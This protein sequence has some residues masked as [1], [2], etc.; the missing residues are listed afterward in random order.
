MTDILVKQFTYT[1][2]TSTGSDRIQ[3][4]YT[5]VYGDGILIREVSD[6]IVTIS[7][8]AAFAKK[9]QAI[10]KYGITAKDGTHYKLDTPVKDSPIEQVREQ[11]SKYNQDKA[12]KIAF[13]E[14]ESPDMSFAKNIAKNNAIKEFGKKQ[15]IQN[16]TVNGAV[17][18]EEKLYRSDRGHYIYLLLVEVDAIIPDKAV[19]EQNTEGNSAILGDA[20]KTL[21]TGTSEPNPDN[22]F[23]K[24]F[25]SS[26]TVKVTATKNSKKYTAGFYNF[27]NKD[28]DEIQKDI[29]ARSYEDIASRIFN[30][31]ADLNKTLE[32]K[33]PDGYAIETRSYKFTT[34]SPDRPKEK[35]APPPPPPPT[36]PLPPPPSKNGVYYPDFKCTK[37]KSAQL[38]EFQVK[39]TKELYRGSYVETF[40]N[41]YFAGK[42]TMETGIE[43]EKVVDEQVD[44]KTTPS[45]S[46][47]F[48]LLAD[49][50]GGLFKRKPTKLQRERG[51]VKRYF[52][53]DLSNKKIAETDKVSYNQTEL[54]VP[55]RNFAEIDWIIKGPAED[56]MFGDYPFEG[57]ESK[58]RKTIQ[59]LNK[60]MPGISTF[61]TDYRYLVEEL[62]AVRP[63]D[64]TSQTFVE[65][66]ANKQLENDRKASFD[67]KNNKT[68]AP[69][70]FHYMPDGTLMSD[71]E[72]LDNTSMTNNQM[73]KNNNNYSNN[74]S[75]NNRSPSGY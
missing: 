58:N 31:D 28:T 18:K 20:A 1:T 63:Q 52:V 70:G 38:G 41:K 16:F 60:A 71:G 61:V 35:I 36:S 10:E 5:K 54:T 75:N 22:E 25:S 72:M 51:V 64:K 2:D 66:D 11:W 14:A 34:V 39:N 59:A 27:Y 45:I 24:Y 74:S 17:I 6:I 69:P 29:W 40:N 56:K 21:L 26:R 57:A 7:E 49:S 48:S 13:G 73:S 50:L 8:E 68:E 3:R 47:P 43:L 62:P 9:K 37:S 33:Y 55:N 4:L 53:Q 65:Q 46:L 30:D 44:R 12:S 32:D 42:S 23:A 67:T 19:T 15:D